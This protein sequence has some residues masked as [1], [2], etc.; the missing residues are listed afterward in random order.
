M[1]SRAP[2]GHGDGLRGAG[3]LCLPWD[4]AVVSRAQ[5]FCTAF[6]SPTKSQKSIQKRSYLKNV[7]FKASSET[8][9][10]VRLGMVGRLLRWSGWRLGTSKGDPSDLGLGVGGETPTLCL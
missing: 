2:Q 7:A 8:L 3:W 6:P 5:L 1:C 4:W 10:Q 9:L